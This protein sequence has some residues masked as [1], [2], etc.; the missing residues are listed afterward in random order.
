M[1]D[2]YTR[3][4]VLRGVATTATVLGTAGPAT[5][6][7]TSADG[8]DVLPG[9]FEQIPLRR[10]EEVRTEALPPDAVAERSTG[11]RP[12]SQLL[13]ERDGTT[14]SCTANFVWRD[15]G[16][17]YYVGAAGHCFLPVGAAASGNAAVDSETGFDVSANEVS[18]AVDGTF[19]GVLGGVLEAEV[20]ELGDVVYARQA[21]R[22]GGLG[23]GHDFGLVEVPD[24][25]MDL[26]DPSVPQFGGPDGV[27]ETASPPGSVVHMYGAGIV[28]GELFVTQ[29]RTGISLGDAGT[30]GSWFGA[31]RATPGDSGG[32]LL[33]S[34]VGALPPA[35][36]PATGILTHVS[37][38]GIAGTTIGRCEGLAAT[39]AGLDLE[40]V[41]A[42]E[43]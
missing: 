5:A 3:R 25:A 33:E 15:G 43:L 2:R 21:E 10:F 28:N 29:G 6:A 38:S 13:V 37:S 27:S 9:A 31:L 24:E 35:A 20:V 11:I 14:A 17:D 42:G 41:R 39:D 7:E 34:E 19:G 12:G 40:V 23:V 30:P 4:G 1:S 26:V 18:I 36:G 8:E 32:P 16:G 22:G